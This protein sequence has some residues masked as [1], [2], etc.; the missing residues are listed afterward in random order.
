MSIATDILGR[1]RAGFSLA[2]PAPA[3][4]RA[5]IRDG[6]LVHLS[7]TALQRY[8]VVSRLRARHGFANCVVNLTGDTGPKDGWLFGYTL[9][10]LFAKT[11][12]DHRIV[13]FRPFQGA[14]SGRMVDFVYFFLGEPERWQ[15]E[16]QSLGSKGLPC[17]IRVRGV[18]VLSDPERELFWRRGLFWEG[19]RAVIVKGGYRGPAQIDR[20]ADDLAV[21]WS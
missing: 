19:D 12:R 15:R 6:I 11:V 9:S 10:D 5:E 14:A 20:F 3:A 16:A 1:L 21:P 2:V 18:D 7:G 17:T 13:D 4:V 8:Y